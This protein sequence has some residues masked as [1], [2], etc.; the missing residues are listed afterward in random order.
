[1]NRNP[2]YL[3]HLRP[4]WGFPS[5]EHYWQV[6]VFF[7]FFLGA[8]WRKNTQQPSWV[9]SK[10]EWR[11][12]I[13][14]KF[15]GLTKTIRWLAGQRMKHIPPWGGH[16]SGCKQLGTSTH[17]PCSPLGRVPQR[18]FRV[19]HHLRP[20]WDDP[21]KFT[22]LNP[23]GPFSSPDSV[24]CN[25]RPTWHP[26]MA[27]WLDDRMAGASKNGWMAGV[28]GCNLQLRITDF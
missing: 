14:E 15:R 8:R 11:G 24:S 7:W 1:M 26:R 10:V 17:K 21:S 3:A 4:G 20:S 25:D 6:V 27:G 28:D 19:I 12:G 5:M 22:T 16:P 23:S 18:Q 2:C 9:G 13:W